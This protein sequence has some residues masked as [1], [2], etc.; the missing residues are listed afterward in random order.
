MRKRKGN[1]YIVYDNR[2]TGGGKGK[3]TEREEEEEEKHLGE[4]AREDGAE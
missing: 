1:G 3:E 2:K 4:I